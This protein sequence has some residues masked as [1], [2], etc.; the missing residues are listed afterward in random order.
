M[1]TGGGGGGGERGHNPKFFVW[2]NRAFLSVSMRLICFVL[3]A[4]E[5]PIGVKH[6]KKALSFIKKHLVV[7]QRT[8]YHY[9]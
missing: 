3:T 4:E 7:E 9:T 6:L 8:L 2:P 1:D 5:S